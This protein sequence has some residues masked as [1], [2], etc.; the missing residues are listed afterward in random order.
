MSPPAATPTVTPT[1][2]VTPT[3]T[4]TPPRSERTEF[5]VEVVEVVD[6]DTLKVEYADGETETVRLLGVDTPEVHTDTDPAEWSGIPDTEAGR[7]HLRDWGHKASEYARTELE[8]GEE[9]RVVVDSE[10]DRR[11]SYGRLLAYVYDDGDLF[12]LA[13]LRQGYARMYD[14]EFAERSRFADAGATARAN[15][16]GVW[17]FEGATRTRTATATAT[18]TPT[19]TA[20]PAGPSDAGGDD[21]AAALAITEVHADADG[22]DHE[23]LNDEY[24]VLENTGDEALDLSG[25]EVRDEADHSYRFPAGFTLDP[26]QRVTLYTGSGEDTGTELYWE[27]GRAVWNNGGDTIYVYDDRGTLRIERSYS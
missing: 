25:W 2:T 22:N 20:T 13:L 24:L 27:S 16:V 23:N 3:P 6:G 21:P 26:G 4:E 10:A 12:N 7:A 8:R 9:V 15:D 5:R 14:T 17:G 1:A 19:P 11:G 18:P